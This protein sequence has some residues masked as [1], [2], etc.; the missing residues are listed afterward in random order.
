MCTYT[1][2]I[3]F[4]NFNFLHKMFV[5]SAVAITGLLASL[6][7]ALPAKRAVDKSSLLSKRLR[8]CR[9]QPQTQFDPHPL[10]SRRH[11]QLVAPL[12]VLLWL[13]SGE[14]LEFQP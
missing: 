12:L 4:F 1:S 10:L 2:F 9:D 3:S 7:N 5:R 11:P 6:S 14:R 13:E 8:C